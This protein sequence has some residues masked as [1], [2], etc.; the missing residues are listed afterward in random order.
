MHISTGK[1]TKQTC[2]RTQ[3]GLKSN[4]DRSLLCGCWWSD[5][6]V[7]ERLMAYEV[8]VRK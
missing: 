8:S 2:N 6:V 1:H 5:F 4:A 7:N 3:G